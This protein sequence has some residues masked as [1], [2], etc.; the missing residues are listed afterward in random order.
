MDAL[1]HNFRY[2]RLQE[3]RI[4]FQVRTYLGKSSKSALVQDEWLELNN[5]EFSNYPKVQTL[6]GMTR[7]GNYIGM[8]QQCK[9]KLEVVYSPGDLTERVIYQ[10]ETGAKGHG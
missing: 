3:V 6:D 2:S 4:N 9:K 8:T 5:K 7:Q 10:S 1:Y